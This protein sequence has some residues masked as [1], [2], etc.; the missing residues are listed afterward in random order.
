MEFFHIIYYI[1]RGLLHLQNSCKF[2]LRS[3]IIRF[4]WTSSAVDIMNHGCLNS[5]IC[6]ICEIYIMAWTI[7]DLNIKYF[8]ISA[9]YTS[10]TYVRILNLF[11][12]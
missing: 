10:T 2:A 5:Q 1:L 4:Y 3:L 8:V 6:D 11:Q 9:V 12:T 7:T